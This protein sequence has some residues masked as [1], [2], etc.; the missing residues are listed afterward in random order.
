MAPDLSAHSSTAARA[1][2]YVPKPAID[3]ARTAGNPQG[4]G[5]PYPRHF[6]TGQESTLES[7]GAIE[8]A[9]AADQYFSWRS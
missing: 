6:A 8:S 5:W 1:E 9:D 2:R 4:R 7:A 3:L